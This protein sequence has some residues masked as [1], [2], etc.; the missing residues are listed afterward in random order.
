M[1]ALQPE[2]RADSPDREGLPDPSGSRHETE[3]LRILGDHPSRDV[4]LFQLH[5][6][7]AGVLDPPGNVDR[8]ELGA[9]HSGP[10]P[11]E[12][13]MPGRGLAEIVRF[14]VSAHAGILP[15]PPRQIREDSSM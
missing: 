6:G 9:Y 15:D 12:V 4:E 3:R 10:Q 5:P 2:Q 8:P 14:D 11:G 1:A 13:G 7:K